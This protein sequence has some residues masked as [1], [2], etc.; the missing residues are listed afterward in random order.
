MEEESTALGQVQ[1]QGSRDSM[2][3]MASCGTLLCIDSDWAEFTLFGA[4]GTGW[5]SRTMS[6][7]LPFVFFCTSGSAGVRA[8]VWSFL[9]GFV[10]LPS[11]K[12]RFTVSSIYLG[13]IVYVLHIYYKG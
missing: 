9:V 11:V 10:G 6:F 2:G 13:I 5:W 3:M 12:S 7:L 8:S 1:S 4:A